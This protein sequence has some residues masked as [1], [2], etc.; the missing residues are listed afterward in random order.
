MTAEPNA[1]S[2]VRLALRGVCILLA[3]GFVGLLVYGVLARNPNTSIDDALANAR[4]APAP[5]F[6]LAVLQ[7]G[8]LGSV[9]ARWRGAAA[10]RRVDL[11][12]LRGTPIVL[13]YWASWCV[14]CRTEAPLLERGWRKSRGAGVLF[15]GLNMQDTT[16]DARNFIGGFGLTFPDVRDGTNR[17]ARRWGVTGIPETFFISRQG[18]VVGHVIGA[19]N[20]AQLTDGIAAAQAGRPRIA[21]R[22]GDRRSTR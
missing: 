8:D 13:N 15:L 5:G 21:T 9:S 4:A 12:E 11:A 2:P 16:E 6:E 7:N 22:G 18:R 14:P 1:R 17:T 19:M 20:Q 10:D 3:L